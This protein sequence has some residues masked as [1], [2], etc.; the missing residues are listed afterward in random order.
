[1][2]EA[3]LPRPVSWA[4]WFCLSEAGESS[5]RQGLDSLRGWMAEAYG[6]PGPA[7]GWG[8][9]SSFREERFSDGVAVSPADGTTCYPGQTHRGATAHYGVSVTV[10]GSENERAQSTK[11][12]QTAKDCNGS[13]AVFRKVLWGAKDAFEPAVQRFKLLGHHPAQLFGGAPAGLPAPQVNEQLPGKGD[14]GPLARS[15]MGLGVEQHRAPLLDQVIVGL[16]EQQPPGQLDQG[17]CASAGCPL[18]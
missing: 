7:L 16:V 10:I 17:R 18:W 11:R 9:K 3:C 14:D 4:G 8:L 12:P 2:A 13:R 5:L 15:P 1:M 6:G